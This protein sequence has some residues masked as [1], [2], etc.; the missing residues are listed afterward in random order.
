MPYYS[1]SIVNF[2]SEDAQSILGALALAGGNDPNQML[3]WEEEISLLKTA[4]LPF[5]N[6]DGR[7]IF[8]YTIPRMGKR[9]DVALLLRGVIYI[10]EFKCGSTAFLRGD[11]EQV[12]DY[13][14]DL[15]YFHEESAHAPI[16]PILIATEA[17]ESEMVLQTSAYDDLVY[18]P[19]FSNAKSLATTLENVSEKIVGGNLNICDWECSNYQPTPTI[20][21]AARTLYAGNTVENITRTEASG[22]TIRRTTD[23]VKQV[24]EETKEQNGKTICFVTGVPGA[25]KTLVG[26]NIAFLLDNKYRKTK[27]AED[28]EAVYMSGNGPLV[29]VLRAALAKDKIAR[30]R[31][32]GK[33]TKKEDAE[34]EAKTKVQG[35]SEYREQMLKKLKVTVDRKIDSELSIDPQKAK[36]SERNGYAEPEHITVFDEAQR[37]WNKAKIA[38][39]LHRGGS[40]GNKMK[41]DDFPMSEAEFLIWSLNLRPDWAVIIC[42]VGGGQEIH[43]G[44][45]GI[46]EWIRAINERFP[47][48]RVCIADQLKGE[49]YEKGNTQEEIRKIKNCDINS[50]LH[51]SVSMRS[52][53]AERLANW[54]ENVLHFQVE[55]AQ[56]EYAQLASNYPIVLTRDV[57]Q[58]KAWLRQ[59]ARG[60][61]RYGLIVSSKASR[62]RPLAIDV[63]RKVDVVNWFLGEIDLITSSY[64]L[65]DSATEFDIQGLELDWTCV[66]WD[67]DMRYTEAGWTHHKFNTT[68]WSKI[69]DEQAQMYQEN[70]YRVLLT[71]ARQGMVICVPEGSKEDP[72]RDPKFYDGTYEYLKQLGVKEI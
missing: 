69:N 11:A 58:A 8:E 48:W 9:I 50:E 33:R 26:L 63:K 14:L 36:W 67:G 66:V 54:V 43:T 29:K 39:W 1:K 65:E 70:A 35:I 18:T 71:R 46:G 49:A 31:A 56:R 15:K 22:E 68:S 38:D 13:A 64:Y 16:V 41:I 40:Y 34:R 27:K 20:I 55:D 2:L 47:E 37:C 12:M 10:L 59:Q 5:K 3:A 30:D 72:T 4:L 62:L 7:V 60:S 17:L 42:L 25:G 21:E 28:V 61:E 24:V 44:E 6:E 53:R 32:K 23:F 52:F 51:L 57:N 45:A 19:I